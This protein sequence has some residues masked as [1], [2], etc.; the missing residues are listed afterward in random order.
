MN[1]GT[2]QHTSTKEAQGMRRLREKMCGW[3]DLVRTT[4]NDARG[5]EYLERF[6]REE[7]SAEE[8][9]TFAAEVQAMCTTP[10][11]A[12]TGDDPVSKALAKL[13]SV[14]TGQINLRLQPVLRS[15]RELDRAEVVRIAETCEPFI[16][17]FLIN[18]TGVGSKD[19]VRADE[20]GREDQLGI[21]LGL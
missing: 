21:E 10:F 2:Q 1:K 4:G 19:F 5:G 17:A 16:M 15:L 12:V 6:F 11:Y 7:A 20:K 13:S 8:L 14:G 3:S 18:T 9:I